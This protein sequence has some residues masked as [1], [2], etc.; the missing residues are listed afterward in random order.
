[1]ASSPTL[2]QVEEWFRRTADPQQASA[3]AAYLQEWMHAA[4]SNE[5]QRALAVQHCLQLFQRE[6]LQMRFYA[7]TTLG[8][9]QLN[10]PE[11]HALRQRLLQPPPHNGVSAAFLRN[12]VA[13]A[14]MEMILVDV[15]S[16]AWASFRADMAWLAQSSPLVYLKTVETLLEAIVVDDIEKNGT[17]LIKEFLKMEGTTNG[18]SMPLREHF[19]AE[20]T[21]LLELELSRGSPNEESLVL[22]LTAVKAFLAWTDLTFLASHAL[23]NRVLEGLLVSLHPRQA[24]VVQIAAL[25]TWQEW[26]TSQGTLEAAGEQPRDHPTDYHY[27]P[28]IPVMTVVFEKIHEYN[29]LPY[30]GESEAD[31][32]VVIAVA[33][34]IGTFGT[35]ALVWWGESRS[36]ASTNNTA[37]HNESLATLFRQTLDLFFRALAYDDI[38]VSAAVLPLATDIVS[39][40]ESHPSLMEHLP[41][42][43]N[44]LYRQLRYPPDFSYD[45]EDEADAEEEMYRTELDKLY[46]RIVRV[47]PDLCLQFLHEAVARILP[48]A[49]NS[50]AA[51]VEA[52]LRLVYH[53]C[54]GIRPSPGMK[55]VMKEASFCNLLVALHQSDAAQHKH[56]EV[57]RL[58]FEMAVRYYPLYQKTEHGDL[59]AKLL[60]S[61]T[62]AYGLQHEHEQ[63]RSRC[64]FLLLRLVKSIVSLLRPL[65][66][67]AVNGIQ[68]LLTN[69]SLPLRPDDSLYLFE[70]IGILLGKTGLPAQEQQTYLTQVMTPHIRSVEAILT[71]PDVKQ[72]PDHYGELLS[73][74][75]AAIAHLS[76]GFS[77]PSKEVQAVLVETLHVSLRV[78][79]VVPTS[80][81]VR[82]KSMVFLQRMIQCLGPR[83]LPVIPRFLPPLIQYCTPDD[84]TFVAQV[85]DQLCIKFKSDAAVAIDSSLLP[86]L[87]KCQSMTPITTEV[88]GSDIPPHLQTEQLATQKLGFRVLQHI[89]LH[90]V[91]TVLF[92]PAN[93]GSLESILRSVAEG[94]V[95]VTDPVV[96][97]SCLKIFLELTDQWVVQKEAADN[98][99]RGLLT[100]LYQTVI[101]GV[102]FSFGREMDERDAQQSRIV[103]DLS[104]M[105]FALH[106]A[107][108]T[109][110]VLQSLYTTV[111]PGSFDDLPEASDSKAVE[112]LF[113]TLTLK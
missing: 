95:Y 99:Q 25:E 22:C 76:K 39:A 10:G 71:S 8:R 80:E 78:L 98:F 51:D 69:P 68:Q 27:S 18:N 44:V 106:S 19:F 2:A 57:L 100:I 59:L 93:G 103:S 105:I 87:A 73:R 108:E 60:S 5:G 72:D 112:A 97:R 55:T 77:K 96:R 65:V 43:L 37:K 14:L 90:N 58:Y 66:E 64:C 104:K 61:L 75:I 28:S 9:L 26:T 88:A 3:T 41:H 63:V 21:R 45:F 23:T 4:S 54:E 35:E 34:L 84:C 13:H 107:G 30:N 47:A 101:P 31:I 46:G 89:V 62:G 79:E 12:K 110:N 67:R 52:T 6:D 85:F 113:T 17:Q 86:F 70:T 32:E 53:Y 40:T 109:S 83:V 81:P 50:P 36:V 94:A 42:F 92:S 7:L 74:S 20:T 16:G 33:K 29:L 24:A 38:D 91:T 111:P 1:M 11:R 48:S 82:N 15:P 49:S 56:R 102:V